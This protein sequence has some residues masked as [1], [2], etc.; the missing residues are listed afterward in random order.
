MNAYLESKVTLRKYFWVEGM[1]DLT[2]P[3]IKLEDMKSIRETIFY[4]FKQVLKYLPYD[5]P[6]IIND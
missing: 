3:H 6:S 2:Y 4:E 5:I 1:D